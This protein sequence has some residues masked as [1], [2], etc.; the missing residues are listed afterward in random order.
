M[1]LILG[2]LNEDLTDR[3]GVSPTTCSTTFKTWIRLLRILLGDALVKWLP[4][5]AIRDHLPDT[6]RKAGHL[7]LR[8]IIDCIELFVERP[9]ALDLE[10]QNWSDCKNHNTI[11]FLIAISPNGYITFLSDCYSGRASFF[12]IL[13][14]SRFLQDNLFSKIKHINTFITAI[15]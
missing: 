8:Y 5:E 2:I 3:F 7:N 6:Y 11:K 9:K 10:D 13:F 14:T 1:R 12:L 4:R 15:N